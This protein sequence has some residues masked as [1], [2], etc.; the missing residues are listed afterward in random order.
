MKLHLFPL[1]D[2]FTISMQLIWNL[3]FQLISMRKDFFF[4]NVFHLGHDWKQ[5]ALLFF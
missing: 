1:G 4:F 5:H 2:P 3:C